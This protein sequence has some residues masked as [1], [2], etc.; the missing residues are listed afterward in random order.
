MSTTIKTKIRLYYRLAKPGIV[1]GNMLMVVAGFCLASQV[2]QNGTYNLPLLFA[3]MVSV[4]LIMGGACVYNNITDRAIDAKMS[5]TKERALVTGA[6]SAKA[7]YWYASILMVLGF[8]VLWLT[9]NWLTVVI[10]IIGV[11][12]Y[13]LL[14]AWAKRRTPYGP[15]V[16][17][18]AGSV[19]PVAGYT[20]VSGHLDMA[21]VLLFAILFFWQMAHFYAIAIM[22]QKDYTK[23]KIPVYPVVKG[24]ETTKWNIV[25]YIIG[26]IITALA[27]RAF[28]YANVTYAVVM[29]AAGGW[30]LYDALRFYSV[31]EPVVWARRV[32]KFSLLILMIF[33]VTVVISP[34]IENLFS[35]LTTGSN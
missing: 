7:A 33:C 31:A 5:R 15:L 13:V 30:W 11:I 20:A 18:I 14:Y 6:I 16:G 22:G 24:V 4:G 1:Y 26:F 35:Y 12:D 27:L 9:T 3:A 34:S 28:D 10:G 17:T 8:T 32:F 2:W 23:A 21:A 25:W 29:L 19:P